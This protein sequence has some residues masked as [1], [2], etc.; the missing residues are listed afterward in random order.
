MKRVVIL[1][2]AIVLSVLMPV[3]TGLTQ[4]SSEV[5]FEKRIR[6]ILIDR[7]QDCHSIDLAE[8]KLRLDSLA[9]LLKG[10]LRGPAIVP[11]KPEESLLIRAVRHGE[12]LKMPAKKKLPAIEIAALAKWVKDGAVWPNSKPVTKPDEIDPAG[13][14][15]FSAEQKS[16][17]A[18][19]KPRQ[20]SFPDVRNRQWVSTPLDWFNL[21]RLEAA[22]YAPAPKA[23]RRTLFR[24]AS[25]SWLFRC[26][27]FV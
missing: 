15:S 20:A 22:G 23:D 18:F 27:C 8:S 6:P 19:Q 5:F 24:R 17:W 9:G 21:A 12:I 25:R 26:F 13:Q 2:A 10:G 3:G 4:D 16:F 11:G 7:C 1:T 14:V